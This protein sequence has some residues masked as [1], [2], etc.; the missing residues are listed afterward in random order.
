[1][2]AFD[3]NPAAGIEVSA[4]A[5]TNAA[6]AP[7]TDAPNP[8]GRRPRLPA[9][10]AWFQALRRPGVLALACVAVLGVSFTVHPQFDPDFWWHVLVGDRILNGNFPHTDPFT[11]TAVGHQFIPQEW[12]SEVLYALLLHLGMWAVIGVMAVVTVAGL[13]IAIGRAREYTRSPAVLAAV[14]A[15]ALAVAVSTFGPRSQMFTFTFSALLLAIL[16]RHRRIGG[17]VVWWC[18]PLFCLWGNLHGGFTIGLGLVVIVLA[19]ELVEHRLLPGRSHGA[20]RTRT[21]ALVLAASVAVIGVNPNGYAML[22]YAG[23]LL[24]NSVA[25]ANLAEWRSPNFHDPTFLPLALLIVLLVVCACKARRVPLA[26]VLL[27]AAGVILTLFAVRNLSLVVVLTAPLLVDGLDA[28][29]T[30]LGLFKRRSAPLAMPFCALALAVVT[31]VSAVVIA[32]RLADP[33][34][35][36]RSAVYPVA[37][38]SA[39]CATP[40][41]NVLEPYGSS[42]WL[43]FEM[44]R[45]A[46]R[47]CAFHPV[48]IWGDAYTMGPRLFQEDLDA[49]AA[50]PDALTILDT[51]GVQTVWQTKGDPL[52]ALLQ[53]TPGW[54]CVLGSEGQVVYTRSTLAGAWHADRSGCP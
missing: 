15:L 39:L 8:A 26:D 34:N 38:A 13:G 1:M 49:V 27:A 53:R 32:N 20:P 19:A 17:R 35:N 28:W 2:P 3:L 24:A 45:G 11:F 23:N 9:G 42:G 22:T 41:S 12:G 43:L 30:E 29:A 36:D 50:R 48:F 18:V 4:P 25:Q 14:G 37:V 10:P 5:A 44:V 6:P 33:L 51:E 46:P 52:P 21:L 54:T 7:H 16:D 40:P 47:P 31:V